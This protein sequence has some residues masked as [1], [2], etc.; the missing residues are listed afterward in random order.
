MQTDK[1][2]KYCGGH[3]IRVSLETL[4]EVELK[5]DPVDTKR[6]ALEANIIKAGD[7]EYKHPFNPHT[8]SAERR[9][10]QRG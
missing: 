1:I 2:N 9:L 7:I 6:P 8:L 10:S 3:L 5:D 4:G